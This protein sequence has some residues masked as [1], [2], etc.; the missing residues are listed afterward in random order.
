MDL[1]DIV[2]P[3]RALVRNNRLE[4]ASNHL[5]KLLMKYWSQNKHLEMRFDIRPA[6]P[7]DPEGMQKGTNLW[8]HVYN[9]RHKA[10][11]LLGRRSRGFVWFFSFLAWFWCQKQRDIPIILLL[12]EPGL[13]LH[14]Q[15]QRDLLRYLEDESKTGHQVIY[16]THSPFMV[17]PRRLDRVRIV[18]DKSMETEEPSYMIKKGTQVLV[19]VLG[20]NEESILPLLGAM[21][22]DLYSSLRIGENNLLVEGVPDLLIL[23]AMSTLLRKERGGGLDDRWTITPV[24]GLKKI[25]IFLSLMGFKGFTKLAVL[26]DI[27]QDDQIDDDTF[28]KTGLLQGSNVFK[29]TDF[30]NLRDAGVED[31]FEIDF[32]LSLVNAEYGDS[33]EKPIM[34]SHLGHRNRPTRE[35]FAAYFTEN[36]PS[37][38]AKFDP[39][40]PAR[41]FVEHCTEMKDS[42]GEETLARFEQVFKKINKL[43]GGN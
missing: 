26:V 4:G 34:K 5:T 39:I 43:L 8:G 11:T 25:P 36:P 12:D 7:D 42:L 35:R 17:D 38:G 1:N 37:E 20:V 19:N 16:T 31:M 23:K 22:Y 18:E 40:G 30:T 24:G 41:H 2:N 15:A 21:G 10:S 32:Y 27:P 3:A 9:S 28:S 29:Y 33:L 6:L 14:G 13:I